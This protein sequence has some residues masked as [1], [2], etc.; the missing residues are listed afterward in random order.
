MKITMANCTF[1][2]SS[3][4]RVKVTLE[5]ENHTVLV[6]SDRKLSE[7]EKQEIM[8]RIGLPSGKWSISE[9]QS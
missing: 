4:M 8:R 9:R 7:K 1:E 3:G 5:R 2:L 6:T